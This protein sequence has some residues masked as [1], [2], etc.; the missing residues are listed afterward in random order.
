[1]IEAELRR[2]MSSPEGESV[3]FKPGLINRSEIAE[4]CVGIGN[5]GG[6]WLILGVSDKMPRHMIPVKI[7]PGDEISRIRESVADATQIHVE[8]HTVSSTEGPVLAVRIP[9]RPQGIPF[10]TRSGKYLIR[11]GDG[12]RGMTIAEIDAIRRE[13]GIEITARPLADRP[14]HVVSPSG[15]EELRRLMS[16]AGA[17][18]DLIRLTD[19]DLLRSLGV[20]SDDGALLMATLLLVGKPEAIRRHL[21]GAMWQSAA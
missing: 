12:L 17:A 3:E 9:S 16:E 6:G 8:I 15:M 1:M 5:A 11:H 10:H 20:F 19:L 13:A 7:R 14:E 2:I 18:A 4:Y 21:P